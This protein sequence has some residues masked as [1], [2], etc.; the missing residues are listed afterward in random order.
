[1]LSES[2]YLFVSWLWRH[3]FCDLLGEGHGTFP[4]TLDVG[5]IMTIAVS[6]VGTGVELPAGLGVAR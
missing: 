2:T 6:L 1:M 3:F 5:G 4:N